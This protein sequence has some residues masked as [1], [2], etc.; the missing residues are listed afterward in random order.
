MIFI[1]KTREEHRDEGVIGRKHQGYILN[2][3]LAD[4]VGGYAFFL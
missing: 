4:A 1:L 3:N 2:R